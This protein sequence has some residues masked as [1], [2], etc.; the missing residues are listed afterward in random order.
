MLV[1]AWSSRFAVVGLCALLPGCGGSSHGKGEPESLGECDERAA[2]KLRV[3]ADGKIE[4]AGQAILN[5]SCASGECHDSTASSQARHSAPEGVNFDL[6]PARV[7]SADDPD[8]T[9]SAGLHVD[10]KALETLRVNQERVYELRDQLWERVQD[11]T[12]PPRDDAGMQHRKAIAGRGVLVTD[13]TSCEPEKD[14]AAP[15]VD[16]KTQEMLRNW[17]ACG[18]PLVESS[19]RA[20][21]VSVLGQDPAGMP[22]TVGQQMPVCTVS[23]DDPLAFDALYAAVFAPFCTVGCHEP[24]GIAPALDLSNAD[25]AYDSLLNSTG[26]S[27]DCNAKPEALV[28]PKSAS[29][30][31]LIAK[32]GGSD[33]SSLKLCGGA[34]PFGQPK[35]DCGVRQVAAW[36]THGAKR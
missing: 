17:L 11:G 26:S 25:V 15:I 22:G 23:C 28:V 7:L 3:G 8:S 13:S 19:D 20:V 36:I 27:E 10:A 5:A 34:E 9:L 29:M 16:A 32:M 33:I 35:L 31:Y 30:S 4:Y 21:R 18:A 1:H 24:A 12:M 2:R 14:D 6:E